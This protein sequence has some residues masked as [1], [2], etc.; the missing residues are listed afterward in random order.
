MKILDGKKGH[1]T[2]TPNKVEE[3]HNANM[4][5]LHS[6]YR[7]GKISAKDYKKHIEAEKKNKAS[8]MDFALQAHGNNLRNDRNSKR[9]I[10]QSNN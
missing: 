8:A 4:A 9:A 5:E 10:G 1:H 2:M 7:S 6:M 3:N